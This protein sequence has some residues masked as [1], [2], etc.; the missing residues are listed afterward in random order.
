MIA[1]LGDVIKIVRGNQYSLIVS[2]GFTKLTNSGSLKSFS[3]SEVTKAFVHK[4]VFYFDPSKEL[5]SDNGQSFTAKFVQDACRILNI[6]NSFNTFYHPRT[7]GQV[8]RFNPTLNAVIHSY[9]G[10]HPTDWD[11]YTLSLTYTYNGLRHTSTA[12]EPFE[13]V[14]SRPPPPLALEK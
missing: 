5:L 14:L 12:L 1:V 7:I 2:D 4:W 6:Y 11:L 9:R 3:A 10:S 13:L 8:E